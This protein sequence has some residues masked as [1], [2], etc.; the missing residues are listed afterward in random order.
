ML[1][2]A[3]NADLKQRK[4]DKSVED[5]REKFTALIS[6]ANG[7]TH[8]AYS[9]FK[10]KIWESLARKWNNLYAKVKEWVSAQSQ[11]SIIR[12]VYSRMQ[13]RQKKIKNLPFED[14]SRTKIFQNLKI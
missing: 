9:W 2:I 7:V 5:I 14:L 13:E 4:Y 11:L 10:K 6:S 3:K 1:I 12:A 8:K